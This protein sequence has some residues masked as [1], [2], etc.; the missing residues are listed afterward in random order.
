MLAPRGFPMFPVAVCPPPCPVSRE[1][2]KT[3]SPAA[4]ALGS[5]EKGFFPARGGSGG[6]PHQPWGWRPRPPTKPLREG[7]SCPKFP[8]R[9]WLGGSRL[10]KCLPRQ[11]A[12]GSR[13]GGTLPA[14]MDARGEPW[15]CRNPHLQWPPCRG[16]Q[17][18]LEQV[19]L[20]LIFRQKRPWIALSIARGS[21]LAAGAEAHA[22]P[23]LGAGRDGE[24]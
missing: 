18:L 21:G 5:V 23:A 2:P 4:K 19:A 7:L 9:R 11:E 24:S 8:R 3:R 16:H 17:A 10:T 12:A 15:E 14:L 6:I 13:P 1:V 20:S 22:P